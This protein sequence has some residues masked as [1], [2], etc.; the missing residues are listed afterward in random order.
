MCTESNDSKWHRGD[1]FDHL[2]PVKTPWWAF[3][4]KTKGSDAQIK[5]PFSVCC[6]FK[7]LLQIHMSQNPCRSS[8]QPRNKTPHQHPGA[9]FL[10]HSSSAFMYSELVLSLRQH[11]TPGQ[12]AASAH[13]GWPWCVCVARGG[14]THPHSYDSEPNQQGDS[15]SS[16]LS[17]QHLKCYSCQGR[18]QWAAMDERAHECLSRHKIQKTNPKLSSGQLQMSA[19][20]TFTLLCCPLFSQESWSIASFAKPQLHV[21]IL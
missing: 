16:F 19:Q 15:V 20:D 10:Q 21:Q 11:P 14:A 12:T 6:S 1:I 2:F 18:M 4:P 9:Q 13:W 17:G 7:I 3:S 5:D 8:L